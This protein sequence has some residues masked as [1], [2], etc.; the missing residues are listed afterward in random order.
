MS[1]TQLSLALV[2]LMGLAASGWGILR[3][4]S[5]RESQQVQSAPPEAALLKS[6][7]ERLERLVT[8]SQLANH[9]AA[10]QVPSGVPPI[11]AA[12]SQAGED[13]DVTPEE[14]RAR[15]EDSARREEQEAI[16]RRARLDKT[17]HSEAPD[18]E[19]THATEASIRSWFGAPEFAG[20]LA[21]EIACRATLCRIEMDAPPDKRPQD[22]V[23]LA[24]RHLASFANATTHKIEGSNGQ[25][26]LVVY[27][28]RQGHPLP[29]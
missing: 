15:M 1:K 16:E 5:D 22:F 28:G 19:W 29:R 23:L 13:P 8:L 3:A 20:F 11:N 27:V 18:R 12:S 21:K 9:N 6:K 26:R 10:A 7:V 4:R 2:V 24:M 25:T 14:L 17:L